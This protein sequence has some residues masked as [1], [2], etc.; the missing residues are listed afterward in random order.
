MKKRDSPL[1]HI[2]SGY[3]TKSGKKISPHTRGSFGTRMDSYK[4]MEK[5]PL[6]LDS[7]K[8]K[9]IGGNKPMPGDVVKPVNS[10]D[11]LIRSTS[12]GIIEGSIGNSKSEY[13]VT[14]NPS[15]AP[16]WDRGF[17][18]SSGG[19]AHYIKASRMKS[20]G[21]KNQSFQYFPHGFMGAGLSKYKTVKVKVWKVNLGEKKK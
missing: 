6:Y 8:T 16:W 5:N 9:R 1:R 17:V 4:R 7:A 19:P 20:A 2:V 3:K 21:W 15:P 12:Y 18:Q 13:M 10:Q 14:F 11:T